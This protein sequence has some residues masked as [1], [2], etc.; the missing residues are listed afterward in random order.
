MLNS[1]R[2][3]YSNGDYTGSVFTKNPWVA[4]VLRDRYLRLGLEVHILM[5]AADGFSVIKEVF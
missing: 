4:R 5:L 1:Y 2:I 3:E